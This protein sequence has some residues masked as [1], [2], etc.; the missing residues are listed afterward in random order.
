MDMTT[1][2]AHRG[3][4]PQTL[5]KLYANY[6]THA[7]IY[8]YT[9]KRWDIKKPCYGLFTV[10]SLY[11]YLYLGPRMKNRLPTATAT[12]A[13]AVVLVECKQSQCVVWSC[14]CLA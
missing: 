4:L 1:T 3:L 12:P 11:L 13:T 8:K 2:R 10:P 14:N 6:K 9:Q 5:T 7:Q